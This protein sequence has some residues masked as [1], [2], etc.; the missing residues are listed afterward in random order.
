MVLV[1]DDME[2]EPRD[3]FL[4]QAHA[5]PIREFATLASA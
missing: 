5:I 2:F 1:F 4:G 3:R